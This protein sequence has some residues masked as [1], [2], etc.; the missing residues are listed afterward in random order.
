MIK[1]VIF[2]MNG[3]IYDSVPYT[4]KAREIIL[5]KFGIKRDPS[6][7]GRTLGMSL[8]DQI[9]IMNKEYG[10]SLVYAD[11]SEENRKIFN[12]ITKGKL[13]PN[14][15]VR[16][17]IDELLKNKIEIGIASM[18]IAVNIIEH[19]KIMGLREKFKTITSV[20]EVQKH[21]PDP[22]VLLKTCAKMKLEP[23]ECVVIDDSAQ[24][25]AP[26][27]KIGMKIIIIASKTGDD[28]F[29]SREQLEKN[30]ADLVIDSIEELNWEK[31]KN[32]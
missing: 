24:G 4:R 17:L 18:N 1:G 9:E 3:V 16:E 5:A 12:E 25:I 21:K 26:A 6:E 30:G 31:I 10:L 7:I 22:E 2:G 11:F 13:K 23:E 27:K 14:P 19:L 20:E 15:G 8:K 32:L 28:P 29:Q